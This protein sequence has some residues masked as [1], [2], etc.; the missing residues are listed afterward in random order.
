V[1]RPAPGGCF[2]VSRQGTLHAALGGRYL[3]GSLPLLPIRLL[4]GV[5]AESITR[6]TGVPASEIATVHAA[7]RQLELLP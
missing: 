6:E 4:A 1:V 5:P 2:A 7:L 3:R